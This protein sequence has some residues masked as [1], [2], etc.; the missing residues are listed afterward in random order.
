MSMDEHDT[1]WR[2]GCG[3]TNPD[4]DEGCHGCGELRYPVEEEPLDSGPGLYAMESERMS[5]AQALKR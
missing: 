3:H 2:C 1:E 5:Q 4:Y